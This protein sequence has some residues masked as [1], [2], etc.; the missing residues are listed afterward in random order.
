VELNRGVARIAMTDELQISG[1]PPTLENVRCDALVCEQYW[2]QG[3]LHE[4]AN[5]IYLQVGDTWH[6]LAFDSSI[7]FWGTQDEPPVP[8]VM[9]E[10]EAEARLDDLGARLDLAGRVLE[11]YEASVIPGGGSGTP[12]VREWALCDVS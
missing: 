2:Y 4:P 10:I 6:R 11:S 7:L 8:Y 1:E 3:D 5:V 9:P 12:G